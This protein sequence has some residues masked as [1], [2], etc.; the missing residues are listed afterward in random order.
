[1]RRRRLGRREILALALLAGAS[2]D[3]VLAQSAGERLVRRELQDPFFEAREELVLHEE[4]EPVPI[5]PFLWR[6]GEPTGEKIAVGEQVRVS[7][8]KESSLG[9]RRFVWVKVETADEA[10]GITTEAVDNSPAAG[11]DPAEQGAG[12]EVTAEDSETAKRT[13]WLRLGGQHR[14][15]ASFWEQL[16]R[17]DENP[18]P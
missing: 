10:D 12:G 15:I 17:V 6:G 8:V 3:P 18:E 1:M 14:A 9:W 4:P 16:Q 13:G 5:L 11:D 2:S 7:E